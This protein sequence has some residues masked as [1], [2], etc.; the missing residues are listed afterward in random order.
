ML[1][2]K[3][4]QERLNKMKK[5]M[6]ENRKEQIAQRERI[7]NQQRNLQMSNLAGKYMNWLKR[8]VNVLIG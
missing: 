3:K 2:E 6:E 8:F 5:E 1:E 7:K 4:K